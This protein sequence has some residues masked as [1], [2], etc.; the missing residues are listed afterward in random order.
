MLP[1]GLRD[2]LGALGWQPADQP[3]GDSTRPDDRA[4]SRFGQSY[5]ELVLQLLRERGSLT[6]TEIVERVADQAMFADQVRGAWMSDILFWGPTLY[7]REVL[8]AVRGMLGRSLVLEGDS[9]GPWLVAPAKA[10]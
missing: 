6:L 2:F 4:S 8:V 10:A 7:R 3:A 9:D 5:E 1:T